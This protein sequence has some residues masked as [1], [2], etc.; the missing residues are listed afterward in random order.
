MRLRKRWFCAEAGSELVHSRGCVGNAG[1][2]SDVAADRPAGPSVRLLRQV[3]RGQVRR[4]E[5]HG[6]RVGPLEAG[7][8]A[9]QRRLPGPVRADEADAAARRND[10]VDVPQHELRTVELRDVGCGESAARTLH[11]DLLQRR[12]PT[13]CV[14]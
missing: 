5:A 7:Q 9:E 4:R 1:A 2:T 3:A 8:D 11:E 6:A 12:K 10:E 14:V 13:G